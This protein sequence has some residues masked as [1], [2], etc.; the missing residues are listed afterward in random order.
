MERTTGPSGLEMEMIHRILE[1]LEE[2]S[3]KKSD[4]RERGREGRKEGERARE[5]EKRK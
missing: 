4:Q 2:S 1:M 5:G 3:A